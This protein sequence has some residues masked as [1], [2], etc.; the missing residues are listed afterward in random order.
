LYLLDDADQA[1]RVGEVAVMEDEAAIL[2]VRI[3]V[4]VVDAVGV[5]QR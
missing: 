1:G 4:Q 5:E 3:L 2:F